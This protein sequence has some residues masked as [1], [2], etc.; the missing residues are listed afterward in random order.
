MLFI[1]CIFYIV[2]VL[3]AKSVL[4]KQTTIIVAL[5]M[6]FPPYSFVTIPG[7]CVYHLFLVYIALFFW[8]INKYYAIPTNFKFYCIGIM[9]GFGFYLHPMFIYC[10]AFFI[11]LYVFTL[12][13]INTENKSA[14]MLL[15]K[16]ILWSICFFIGSIPYWIGLEQNWIYYNPLSEYSVPYFKNISFFESLFSSEFFKFFAVYNN[17]LILRYPVIILYLAAFSFLFFQF[18]RNIQKQSKKSVEWIF[19][20][21][22]IVVFGIFLLSTAIHA[23]PVR[24]LLPLCFI[25][26][27][28]LSF[29][30]S[31]I[32]FKSLYLSIILLCIFLFYNLHSVISA[33]DE[34]K[35]YSGLQKYLIDKQMTFGFADFWLTYKLVFLSDE[36]IILSPISGVDRYD[37]YTHQVVQSEKP[38]YLFDYSDENQKEMCDIF[39]QTLDDTGIFYKKD[40]FYEFIIYHSLNLLWHDDILRVRYFRPV[41]EEYRGFNMNPHRTPDKTTG[42][43][44]S[45][46]SDDYIFINKLHLQDISGYSLKNKYANFW[47][48]AIPDNTIICSKN[49]FADAFTDDQNYIFGMTTFLPPRKIFIFRMHSIDKNSQWRYLCV[50]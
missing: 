31:Y 28:A 47:V 9:S 36:R 46:P 7:Y 27:F 44:L 15:E 45:L 17:R 43:N 37:K 25:T 39:E 24:H 34:K 33:T 30:L 10:I 32:R 6:M 1:S 48:T 41:F 23:H 4:S 16:F 8:M 22:L 3:F 5:I 12:F 18:F 11:S 13:E 20:L 14:F 40:F 42:F 19:S 29:F 21:F 38:F 2:V 35:D 50:L 49:I 26:P